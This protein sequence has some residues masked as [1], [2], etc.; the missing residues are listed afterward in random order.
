[1]A[2]ASAR[3]R[4]EAARIK[5][6]PPT[7]ADALHNAIMERE[8]AR[9]PQAV[10]NERAALEQALGQRGEA[11]GA[12]AA[13][14]QREALLAALERQRTA[15]G[16]EVR[17]AERAVTA[18]EKQLTAAR[19]AEAHGRT[20]GAVARR[21]EAERELERA[22]A[23]HREARE[24]FRHFER[25]AASSKAIKATETYERAAADT[26]A[27]QRSVKALDE[28]PGIRADETHLQ[29]V[30]RL[31]GPLGEGHDAGLRALYKHAE[32]YDLP[33]LKARIVKL[34]GKR[35]DEIASRYFPHEYDQ[36]IEETVGRMAG[37]A[38]GGHARGRAARTGRVPRITAGFE[39]QDRRT[40]AAQNAER[41][42]R[43]EVPI[44]TQADL[45]AFNA[46]RDINRA[47]AEGQYAKDLAEIGRPIR[48]ANDLQNLAPGEAVYRLG[49]KDRQFALHEASDLRQVKFP[50]TAE[51]LAAGAERRRLLERLKVVSDKIRRDND[52]VARTGRPH[53]ADLGSL[54]AERKEIDKRIAAIEDEHG[55]ENLT[56]KSPVERGGQY[57][58][59]H[60]GIVD[61]FV[62]RQ[63]GL[64]NQLA[65]ESKI[66]ALY[67]KGL[68]KFKATAIAT[69]GFHIRNALSDLHLT[70][71]AHPNALTMGRNLYAGMRAARRHAVLAT[72]ISPRT[73][74]GA[75]AA[76][77]KRTVN[78]AGKDQPMDEFLR[79][80]QERGVVDSGYIGGELHD[81][82]D[83]A[84]AAR[85]ADELV[86]QLPT[87]R[88]GML[89]T[90]RH[91]A[92]AVSAGRE[93]LFKLATYKA[94][95][96]KGMSADEAAAVAR[97]FHVDYRNISPL[98]RRFLRRIM[99]FYTWPARQAALQTKLL[100]QKPG[101]AATYTKLTR[102]IQNALSGMSEEERQ[103]ALDPYAQRQ[104][105]IIIS[106]HGRP[107]TLSWGDPTAMVSEFPGAQT[108]ASHN[109]MELGHDLDE[110]VKFW[111]TGNPLINSIVGLYTGKNPYTRGPIAES[112]KGPTDAGP[113][114]AAPSLI[115]PL[116]HLLP[117]QVRD[118]LGIVPDFRDPK[119]GR[120]GW[121]WNG[122]ADFLWDQL[123]LGWR[124]QLAQVLGSGRTPG[125]PLSQ[126]VGGFVGIGGKPVT[127][128]GKRADQAEREK[129]G[130]VQLRLHTLRQ[131]GID[132]AHPNAEYRRLRKLVNANQR[133][134]YQKAHPAPKGAIKVPSVT[135]PKVDVPTV[136]V[137]A[138]PSG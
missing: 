55:L 110:M 52:A 81:M 43:G 20:A 97:E 59:L 108:L 54:K 23:V 38:Q 37:M 49:Y 78:V 91:K 53:R 105:A 50:R 76:L 5:G 61:H 34:M 3:E 70:Y 25:E 66:A 72:Q 1:L 138:I 130:N 63:A 27:A 131:R 92:R 112:G 2:D 83:T 101:K 24:R 17:S 111:G 107:I 93:N 90:L 8:F 95:L 28:L 136:N 45:A 14:S 128:P 132:A 21:E 134:A 135:V 115:G 122:R 88:R 68:Q 39:R 85:S 6:V 102:D 82:V 127:P 121:G 137:P 40:V 129:I 13:P 35:P 113:L 126:Q 103:Q 11:V 18:A 10:A 29:Y 41:A 30:R 48:N 74:V 12:Q 15:H 60:K 57:V 120:K 51:A 67:D 71:Q 44:S 65:D 42:E 46:Y 118:G 79:G 98:E 62:A 69:L 116:S 16:T 47:A 96:D 64:A 80:A 124:G 114:R 19:E 125:A 117:R 109:P 9:T 73:E 36:R 22:Q 31:L 26:A 133:K 75:R 89:K 84:G 86:D 123:Q 87:T 106:W 77:A 119:T 4:V 99:P 32:D 7:E 94:M 104:G 100:F 58:A 56:R 33:E